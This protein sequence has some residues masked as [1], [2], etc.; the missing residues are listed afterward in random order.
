MP[1]RV[2]LLLRSSHS[3]VTTVC[4]LPCRSFPSN[5]DS[6]ARGTFFL[7]HSSRFCSYCTFRRLQV[8]RSWVDRKVIPPLLRSKLLSFSSSHPHHQPLG[9]ELYSPS[10]LFREGQSPSSPLV[11]VEGQSFLLSALRQL[12]PVLQGPATDGNKQLIVWDASWSTQSLQGPR[13]PSARTGPRPVCEFWR[14]T[15]G[16]LELRSHSRGSE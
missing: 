1:P 3:Q 12:R 16:L 2:H 7:G 11:S 6:V 15:G 4:H 9:L 5:P 10:P 13:V 14:A 8:E